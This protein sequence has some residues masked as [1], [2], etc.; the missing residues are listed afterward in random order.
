MHRV[1]QQELSERGLGQ[2][3]EYFAISDAWVPKELYFTY[4]LKLRKAGHKVQEDQMS[5]QESMDIAEVAH[6]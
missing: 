6:S 4:H 1:A 3:I 2:A 5:H